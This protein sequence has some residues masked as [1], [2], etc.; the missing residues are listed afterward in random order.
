MRLLNPH[1]GLT[2]LKCLE[3]TV[4][5]FIG[6]LLFREKS[7]IR[8]EMKEMKKIIMKEADFCNLEEIIR[9]FILTEGVE[10]GNEIARRPESLRAEEVPDELSLQI[11]IDLDSCDL[12][13]LD[14]L[15]DN[16]NNDPFLESSWEEKVGCVEL[17]YGHLWNNSLEWWESASASK[18][19]L[20]GVGYSYEAGV[21]SVTLDFTFWYEGYY[22]SEDASGGFAKYLYEKYLGEKLP[23]A[24]DIESASKRDLD[25]LKAKFAS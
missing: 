2:Y 13:E 1:E 7:I 20:F 24:A 12:E 3:K 16:L 23:S 15:L 25:R 4:S 11:V 18:E 6:P 19:V 17:V 9:N 8:K 14:R 5:L 22:D 21:L 10:K